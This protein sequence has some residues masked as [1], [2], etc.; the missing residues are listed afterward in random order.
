MES[1]GHVPRPLWMVEPIVGVSPGAFA[2]VNREDDIPR[3]W[4]LGLRHLRGQLGGPHE[5][6]D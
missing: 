6:T 4:L 5:R 2:F 3:L 1:L